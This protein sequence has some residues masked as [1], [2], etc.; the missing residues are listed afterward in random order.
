MLNTA[1]L[2]LDQAPPISIPFRFFLTAPLFGL[3]AAGM[4]LINGPDLFLTRWSPMTLGL[5]H[6]LTLGMLAMVMCGALLQMLP[7]LAGSPVPKV[8]AVGSIC[9][10][11][12]TLGTVMLVF[13]FLSGSAIGDAVALGMLGGGIILF[14]VAVMIALWRVKSVSA[15]V[16]AIR[17]AVVSLL[18]TLLLG[19]L[20]GSGILGTMGFGDIAS[21]V[22]VHLGWGIFG[23]IGL[24]LIGIS[25][26]VVPMFQVTP[27][28]PS[29]LRRLL[30]PALFIGMLI[31]TALVL[32]E[33]FGALNEIVPRIWMFFLLSGF[34]IYAVVT[35]RLQLQRKRRIPDITMMFWRTG[36]LFVPVCALVW[37]AGNLSPGIGYNPHY[38]LLLGVSLLLGVGVSVING[39]LYKIVPFLSWFHLQN[40]QMGLMCMTVKVPNMKEFISDK[41]ARLQFRLFLLA[42][43]SA[44]LATLRPDWFAHLAGLFFFASNALLLK[45]LLVAML[46]YRET[47]R[48]LLAYAESVRVPD[49]DVD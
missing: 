11:M 41:A 47:N 43:L 25:Y 5:T 38:N 15:T 33:I 27:E 20:L 31:W 24:L 49:G 16:V 37:V 48:A 28:Y 19:L 34:V 46:R 35:V 4:L 2:S 14:F 36:M 8:V 17:L 26:Q 21:L 30:A 18:I 40:R 10:L 39:M 29:R 12:I 32:G 42:L 9:H 44:L 3:A 13:A 7:V 45:N 1:N 23:W 22:D 6:M